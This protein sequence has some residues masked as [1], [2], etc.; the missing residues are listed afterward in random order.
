VQILA[1][2]DT[3]PRVS[4]RWR[5]SHGELQVEPGRHQACGRPI[6]A[7]VRRAHLDC[8]RSPTCSARWC[9]DAAM[10]RGSRATMM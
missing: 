1:V 10:S 3:P 8:A 9:S 5:W 2:L 4:R 7:E 6:G